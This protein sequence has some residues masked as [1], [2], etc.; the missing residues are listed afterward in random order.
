MARK[1]NIINCLKLM[2]YLVTQDGP[3]VAISLRTKES[4]VFIHY[5]LDSDLEHQYIIEQ[6]VAEMNRLVVSNLYRR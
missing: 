5:I 3:I 1:A 2:G 6:I 4:V